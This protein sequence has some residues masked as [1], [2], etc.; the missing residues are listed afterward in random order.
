LRALCDADPSNPL[1][2]PVNGDLDGFPPTIL[3]SCTRDLLLSD[4]VRM[5]RALR[6]A[7]VEAVLHVYDG[8]AHGDYSQN[9]IRYV[10]ECEDAQCELFEFFDGHLK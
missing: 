6:A 3:I 1:Q 10:A 7:G 2:S 9:P 4:T 5:L 8:Q